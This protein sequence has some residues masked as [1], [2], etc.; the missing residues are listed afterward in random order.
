M[1]VSNDAE[2]E[3]KSSAIHGL[4]VFAG[5]AIEAG[6]RVGVYE[7]AVTE[8]NGT[9]VLWVMQE[10]GTEL[11]IDGRNELRFLNHSAQP[12]CEF[13]GTDLL[14]LAEIP[15]GRELTFHYGEDWA[16]IS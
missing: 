11:G 12:N 1:P 9:Y 4:G 3:V 5:R 7:G 2:V 15:A 8:D 6:A 13:D 14:A 10:D 16:E